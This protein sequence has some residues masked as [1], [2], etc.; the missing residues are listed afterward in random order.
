[1]MFTS[2][3]TTNIILQV[4]FKRIILPALR[5]HGE[6]LDAYLVIQIRLGNGSMV[7]PLS[8][9]AASSGASNPIG[10]EIPIPK[11]FR[12]VWIGL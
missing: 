5:I 8:F 1:M 12:T 3:F 11:L 6:G 7:S 10:M 9:A 2:W 4:I